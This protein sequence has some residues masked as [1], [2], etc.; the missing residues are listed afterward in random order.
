[1]TFVADASVIITLLANRHADE[2]LRRRFA[3]PRGVHAPQ[4]VD[5]EVASGIR[6][7][8]IGGKL[9]LPRATDMLIDFSALR[10]IRHPMLP[11]LHRVLELRANLTAYDA[12]Y[13]ALSEEL[14]IPLLT[15]DAKF[16]RTVGHRAEIHVHP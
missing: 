6:G 15:R 16:G 4:V 8:L 3:M 7:L 2:M 10:I 5:A 9:E 14:G 1:M 12:F 13:V 11:H